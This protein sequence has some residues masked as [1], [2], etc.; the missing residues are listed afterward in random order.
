MNQV[1]EEYNTLVREL[2]SRRYKKWYQLKDLV[3]LLG[4][5]YKSLK[6]M[7]KDIYL[8]YEPHGSIK[9]E[10]GIYQIHYILLDKFKLKKPRQTTI[11][12]HNWQ[13]NI[14]WTTKEY[15]TKSFHEFLVTKLINQTPYV[16]YIYCIEKDGSDRYHVHMLADVKAKEL[17]PKILE[18]LTFCIGNWKEYRLYCKPINNIGSSVDYLIKNPQ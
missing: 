18:L 11:Y 6:N 15:Y 9:K 7:V 17:K 1:K 16:N 13:T 4:I 8:K 14:S 12:S 2:N 5:S 10:S 3:E